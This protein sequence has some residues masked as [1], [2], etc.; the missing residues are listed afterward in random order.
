MPL[1]TSRRSQAWR[2]LDFRVL[3]TVREDMSVPLSPPAQCVVLCY[4]S[5]RNLTPY[6]GKEGSIK[7]QQ[8]SGQLIQGK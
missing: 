1:R 5:P 8:N 3:A 7:M 4:G 2:H 6:E